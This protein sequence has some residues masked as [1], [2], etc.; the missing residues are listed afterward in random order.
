MRPSITG[1]APRGSGFRADG[2]CPRVTAP[3]GWGRIGTAGAK[4]LQRVDT[5]RQRIEVQLDALDR[6]GGSRLIH[7]SDREYRLALIDRLHGEPPLAPFACASR[8]FY[9]RCEDCG[10][11]KNCSVRLMMVEVRDAIALVLDNR[12]LAAMR[13]LRD[14]PD[15]G[16]SYDI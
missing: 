15:G 8:K 13:A 9:R 3:F 14:V 7:R 10:L 11:E 1:T 2:R 4:T 12:S 6:F 16:L 5:E